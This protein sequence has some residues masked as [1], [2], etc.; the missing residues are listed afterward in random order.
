M[1]KGIRTWLSRDNYGVMSGYEVWAKKP[2]L[3]GEGAYVGSGFVDG[4]C[5]RDFERITR[6]KLKPGE[7]KRVRISVKV[8]S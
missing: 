3:D 7:C 6:F 1:K 2:A 4:F 5:A 8:A